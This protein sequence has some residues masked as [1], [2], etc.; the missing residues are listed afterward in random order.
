M[1]QEPSEIQ[2]QEK[3]QTLHNIEAENIRATGTPNR[4]RGMTAP[5]WRE[6]N[7]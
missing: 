2:Q 6:N 7:E 1:N 5:D 4:F 3:E